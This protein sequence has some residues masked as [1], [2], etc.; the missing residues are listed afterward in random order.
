MGIVEEESAKIMMNHLAAVEKDL[1]ASSRDASLIQA[2]ALG[3]WAIMDE[4]H[5]AVK[6]AEQA[7][8]SAND[9]LTKA[10]ADRQRAESSLAN[11]EKHVCSLSDKVV[12]LEVALE[13]LTNA[14][15]AMERL[16]TGDYSQQDDA[17]DQTKMDVDAE[18]A[19]TESVI[20]AA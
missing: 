5:D 4:A 8:L 13:K 7:T 3:L 10:S 17:K 19:A 12:T 1:V 2:E 20:A 18:A 14:C 15:A 16:R 11:A 6:A 9:V